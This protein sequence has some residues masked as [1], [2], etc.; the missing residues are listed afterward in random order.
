MAV[1]VD[2]QRYWH[3]V[4]AGL[5]S[6]VVIVIVALPLLC[7]Y[8]AQTVSEASAGLCRSFAGLEGSSN[9]VLAVPGWPVFS[10]WSAMNVVAVVGIV[11]LRTRGRS[12]GR[13]RRR[14]PGRPPGRSP[15]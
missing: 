15:A 7:T 13:R 6:E 8:P 10:A 11:L 3:I 1:A 5:L 2:S 9:D 12:G 4:A 14:P